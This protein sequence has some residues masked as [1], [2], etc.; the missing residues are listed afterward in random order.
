MELSQKW[1]GN[2]DITS[3]SS[4][5]I[6]VFDVLNSPRIVMKD[7]TDIITT[8]I[9][10][11]SQVLKCTNVVL[12]SPRSRITTVHDA[13]NRLG[14]STTIYIII[15]TEVSSIFFS[16]PGKL[17]IMKTHWKHNL[18]VASIA[19]SIANHHNL[20]DPCRW[21]LG[22]LIH[23]I[24]RLLMLKVDAC[25]YDM[26]VKKHL[27]QGIGLREAE[28]DLFGYSHDIAG[29]LLLDYWQFPID[30]ADAA[31]D[32]HKEFKAYEDFGSGI[33]IADCIANSIQN[34]KTIPNIPNLPVSEIVIN[35]SDRFEVMKKVTG[36][37]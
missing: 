23:D 12:S 18:M 29:G 5:L 32:H 13:I 25:K 9:G 10:L 4:V 20:P 14:F 37:S 21:F 24:G 34:N 8:D 15:A 33:G 19:E 28:N 27:T 22:G 30:I 6:N 17:G 11:R 2:I 7:L 36:I 26:A 31:Y 1:I 16:V 3:P 35:A